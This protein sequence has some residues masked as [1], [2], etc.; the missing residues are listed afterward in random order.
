[1]KQLLPQPWDSAPDRY[2][3]NDRVRGTVTRIVDF[4]AFVELEPGVEGLIHISELSWSR[5]I[6]RVSEVLKQGETVEAVVLGVNPA[7][8]R[9][10][11][12]LKQTLGDPWKEVAQKFPEGSVI[13]GP[14]TNLAKFGA[15]V[16][17]TEGVEGLIHISDLSAEK[18]INHPQE[19]LKV[20]QVITAQVLSIDAAKRQIK[21]GMKQLVPTGLDEYIAEH[22]IGDTVTGRLMD[23]SPEN[24][25]VELGEGII[26]T[27]RMKA[28]RSVVST[29]C[30]RG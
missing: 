10:S 2:K 20:G 13:E 8:R 29:L 15:F 3:L 7:E 14:V 19:M 1:M 28:Q 5:K 21:L 25:R 27:C 12:G 26:A 16:Q 18:R 23:E 30:K 22:K 4:G 24:A 6:K 17:L 9:I 11:L